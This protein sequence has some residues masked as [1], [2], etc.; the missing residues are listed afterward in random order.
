M[1]THAVH[2]YGIKNCDTMKKALNWLS[3]ENIE[4]I[5]HDYK[6]EGID[7]E[8]IEQWLTQSEPEELINRRGTSWRKLSEEVRSTL[9]RD[10][11]IT[12][13]MDN[14]SLVKRPLLELDGQVHLGFKPDNYAS[15]FNQLK[16]TSTV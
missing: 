4:Y 16:N 1:T 14:P 10:S 3:S 12:L 6:K 2:I 11:A 15:L 7:A 9:S 8:K 5:F 13:I